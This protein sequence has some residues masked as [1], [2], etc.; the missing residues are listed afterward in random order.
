MENQALVVLIKNTSGAPKIMVGAGKGEDGEFSIPI[1]AWPNKYLGQFWQHFDHVTVASQLYRS[2]S[3]LPT[4]V[5]D[6]LAY[7]TIPT[8]PWPGSK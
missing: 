7:W 2:Y 6:S 4:T 1:Y 8:G 3:P 5:A